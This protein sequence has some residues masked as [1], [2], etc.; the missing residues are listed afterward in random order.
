M[1]QRAL[2]K[3]DQNWQKCE[4]DVH[5]PMYRKQA[6]PVFTQ[7]SKY[8]QRINGNGSKQT[9]PR[10]EN[11]SNRHGTAKQKCSSTPNLTTIDEDDNDFGHHHEL[12]R[13]HSESDLT[14]IPDA[15]LLAHAKSEFHLT[16]IA[17]TQVAS[18]SSI[19]HWHNKLPA[20]NR[21][22]PMAKPLH[23]RYNRSQMQSSR[24]KK[25]DNARSP[26]KIHFPSANVAATATAASSSSSRNDCT[27]AASIHIPIVGFEVME[28]RARFTVNFNFSFRFP[29]K[30][31]QT[32]PNF[33]FG[34]CTS[35]ALKNRSQTT[36]GSFCV[37]I[38]I[39]CV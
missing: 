8:I 15:N 30:M 3:R 28:E 37:D 31:H 23:D 19:S 9:P 10:L 36:V 32:K 12:T 21:Q 14:K 38:P 7:R 35:F 18:Q 26:N 33:H 6:Q 5:Q 24:E 27:D 39:L 16:S 13:S 20:K 17:S 29:N 34:R 25:S 1:S 2:K 11:R 4:K 22:F